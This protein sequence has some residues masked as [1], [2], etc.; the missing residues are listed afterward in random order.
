MAKIL[1][2][3]SGVVVTDAGVTVYTKE[4]VAER[5]VDSYVQV[6]LRV[7]NGTRLVAVAGTDVSAATDPIVLGVDAITG[8]R[9]TTDTE[10]EVNEDSSGWLR[11]GPGT[12]FVERT[13]I[14]Q[15]EV[16]H[17]DDQ[18]ANVELIVLGVRV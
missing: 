18:G 13:S 10:I 12:V 15:I 11:R 14:G 3:T 5:E 17:D 4:L 1:S 8:Y 2:T 6:T 9:M 16:R 7:P